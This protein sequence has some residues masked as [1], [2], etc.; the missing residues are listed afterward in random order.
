MDGFA[1]GQFQVDYEARIDWDYLRTD[2]IKRV[3]AAMKAASLPALFLWRDENVRY[4]TNLRIIMLQY[5]ASTTY[6][7]FLHQDGDLV[8]FLSSGELVRAR[9]RMPWINQFEPIPIMDEPGMVAEVV[10]KKVL[11][12]FQRYGV[13]AAQVGMDMMTTQQMAAYQRYLP[14]VE[15]VNGDTV[16]Q[17]V[18]MLKNDQEIRILEEATAIAD[19]VTQT[20]LDTVRPGVREFDVSAEAMRSLF[21]YGGEFAH[22]ASPFVASGER[23]SPPTRFPTDKIIRYG[24]VVFI[25]IGA[26]WN[27]YF[28]DVGRTTICGKA[29]PEQKKIY[30]AVYEAQQT[31]IA[32]MQ[33]GRKIS[34]VAAVYHQVAARYGLA[35]QFINL[36]IGH[37]IGAAPAEPPFVGETQP[38]ARDNTLQPGMV[39]AMEPLIHVDGTRGGGGVRLEDMVLITQDGPHIMS[40]APYEERLLD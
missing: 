29:S 5:R 22:L 8:L 35:E 24:D 4:L 6:G 31:G 39:F 37:G 36:F 26:A 10:G 30:R 38:G 32:A 16:M 18:R 19:A 13:E 15:W 27:G 21:H 11:P 20:A 25:D 33:P 34:E 3:C 12:V 40:R 14:R 23:M 7:L 2:K 28:G 9:Q 1:L 17:S